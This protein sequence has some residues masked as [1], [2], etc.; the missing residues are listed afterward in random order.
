MEVEIKPITLDA[1][2]QYFQKISENQ[3]AN[4]KKFP[5]AIS[6]VAVF[7][8]AGMVYVFNVYQNRKAKKAEPLV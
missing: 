4:T 5:W 2:L 1:R 8:G 7:I 6:I 3:Q